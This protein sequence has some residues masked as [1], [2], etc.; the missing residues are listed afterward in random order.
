MKYTRDT[1]LVRPFSLD[2]EIQPLCSTAIGK[3]PTKTIAVK[4]GRI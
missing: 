2:L 3:L 1:L 4:Q